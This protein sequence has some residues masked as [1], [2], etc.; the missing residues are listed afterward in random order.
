LAVSRGGWG[1][2]PLEMLNDI[3]SPFTIP[4]PKI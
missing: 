2:P 1:H 3:D 4:L